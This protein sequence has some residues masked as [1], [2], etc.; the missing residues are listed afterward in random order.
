MQ[1]YVE[2]GRDMVKG[3][4]M[5]LLG[6]YIPDVYLDS[7]RS[8]DK[9]IHLIEDAFKKVGKYGYYFCLKA[10]VTRAIFCTEYVQECSLNFVLLYV[11]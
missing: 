8:P 7:A 2:Y 11:I 5:E 10:A 1:Y 3:R 4:L 9:W 6:S